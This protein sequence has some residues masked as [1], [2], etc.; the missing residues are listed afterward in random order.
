MKEERFWTIEC[1]YEKLSDEWG[2]FTGMHDYHHVYYD[3]EEA[4]SDY[5]WSV[6]RWPERQFRIMEEYRFEVARSVDED[7]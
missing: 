7:R 4:L 6:S 5:E 2:K 1:M 3:L